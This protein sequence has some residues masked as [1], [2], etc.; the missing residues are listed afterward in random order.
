MRLGEER[1]Y[2]QFR[3]SPRLVGLLASTEVEFTSNSRQQRPGMR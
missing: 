1:S 2:P 3:T